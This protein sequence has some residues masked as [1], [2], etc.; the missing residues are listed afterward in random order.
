MFE[1]EKVGE[2]SYYIQSPAKIGIYAIN[3]HEVY[4]IDSGND[5]DAGRKIRQILDKEGWS[6]RGILNTHS[7]AD[8]IGGNKY[9]QSQTGCKIFANKIENAFIQYPLLEPIT[10]YGGY[11]SKD[12]R[13]KFLMAQ[14]SSSEDFSSVDFP[15]EV[16]I[17]E[18][19]GHCFDMVGFKIPDGTVFLADCISSREILEKYGIPF[20]YD[21]EL[22][23]A[24]LEKIKN[25]DGKIFIPSHT[26]VLEDVSALADFNREKVLQVAEHILDIC[27]SPIVF[28][29][30][31]QQMFNRY[32]LKLTLEQYVLVGSTIKSYLSWLKEKGKIKVTFEDNLLNW[33]TVS[34][35]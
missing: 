7:H 18:L 15:K 1:L 23:L 28:E 16:E 26:E 35:I 11:P 20:I 30:I 4:L 31:L 21:V 10:L 14:E 17:I 34:E 13:P 2:N 27:K 22:Y 29:K 6:L 3:D 8:H 9:L 32:N 19:P 12:L 24:T 33:E 25:I 5:K